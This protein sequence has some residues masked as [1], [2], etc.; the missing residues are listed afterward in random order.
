MSWGDAECIKA[1]YIRV[2]A[3]I[4]VA[5]DGIKN[6]YVKETHKKPITSAIVAQE[7][8]HQVESV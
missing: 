7:E 4:I 1:R 6:N 3:I 5:I 2:A 8:T